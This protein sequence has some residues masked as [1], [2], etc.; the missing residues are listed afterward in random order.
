MKSM[1]M[2]LGPLGL[3]LTVVPPLLFMAGMLGDGMMKGLMLAGALVW[4]VAAPS[5]MGGGEE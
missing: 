2:I 4:F 3:V 5:F 1:T